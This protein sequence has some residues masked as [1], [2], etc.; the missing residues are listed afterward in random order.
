MYRVKYSYI[1]SEGKK[2]NQTQTFGKK[3]CEYL[4]H[5]KDVNRA[6]IMNDRF[7]KVHNPFDKNY[8]VVKLLNRGPNI[9][10]NFKRLLEEINGIS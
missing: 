6:Q 3:G 5:H 2:H 1:D 4:I 9:F 8:W 7:I 10:E